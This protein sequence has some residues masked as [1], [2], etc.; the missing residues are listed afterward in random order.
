MESKNCD[1]LEN[2]VKSGS[3]QK[4]ASCLKHINYRCSLDSTRDL[5]LLTPRLVRQ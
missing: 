5:V 2:T 4:L 3:T 1:V